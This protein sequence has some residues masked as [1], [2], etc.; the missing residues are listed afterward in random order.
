MTSETIKRPSLLTVLSSALE[1]ARGRGLEIAAG[2]PVLAIRGGRY[3]V[4]FTRRVDVLGALLLGS[5]TGAE[6][7]E[8]ETALEDAAA[9]LGTT[10]EIVVGSVPGSTRMSMR[11]RW[12]R[13]SIR[14]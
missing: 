11:R 4:G 3:A 14:P 10:R 13:V 6:C 12:Q 9:I 5:P 8:F 1:A 2:D 7:Y